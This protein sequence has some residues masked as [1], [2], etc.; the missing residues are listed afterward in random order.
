MSN[1]DMIRFFYSVFHGKTG[2][3]LHVSIMFLLI[4]KTIVNISSRF[5]F[6][7]INLSLVQMYM[8]HNNFSCVICS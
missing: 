1:T 4:V 7:F 3:S 8:F 5:F 6:F 2:Y